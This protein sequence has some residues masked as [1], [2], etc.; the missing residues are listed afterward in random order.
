MENEEEI[1]QSEEFKEEQ[2]VTVETIEEEKPRNVFTNK[3]FV[4]TFFGALVSN[5]GNLL[6][7]FAV[8]FYI[9]ELTGNNATIQGIYLATGGITYV[10]ITLFGGVISDRFHKGKIMY[11]CDYLKGAVIISFTLL[12]MLLFKD[13]TAR[14]VILF[15]IAVLGNAIAAIFSPASASLLPRIVP[16]KSLQQAQ[17]YYSVM[18]SSISIL[19]IILAGILYSILPIN[20]LFLIVG[21]CYIISAISEMF[22]RY[23]HKKSE[24]KLTVKVVFSDIGIGIKYI[25][26]FKMLFYLIIT[27]LFVNFFFSPLT[28][29]F[30]PYFIKADVATKNYMFMENMKPEM[31]N[32]IIS[33]A[34]A[35]GMI[36]MAMIMS[37]KKQ[38]DKIIKGLRIGFILVDVIYVAL[39]VSYILF[40]K[41]T[42][43]VN[44]MLIIF[45]GGALCLGLTLPM[46]NIPTSTKM[47]TLVEKDKLGKVSS[48]VNIGSQGLIPL[49]NLLAGLVITYLG[50]SWLLLV[51]SAGLCLLTVVLFVNKHISQL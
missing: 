43:D 33:V 27:I 4:L 14:I 6:Y 5:L 15:I 8:S 38:K 11:I 37:M 50:C 24:E 45:I 7:S 44:A 36:I 9:L 28:S 17:S 39:A 21:G 12:M 35:V 46:I 20:V 32:S 30:L 2:G 29:N 51:C 1:I 40:S 23:E 41:T 10:L 25:F 16:Q 13:S 48:A 26:N 22:I 31:W 18:E 47:M 3:N 19:G 42:I 34:F 49:S